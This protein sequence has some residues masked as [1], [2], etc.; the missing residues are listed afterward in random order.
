MLDS[1][2]LGDLRA[3]LDYEKLIERASPALRLYIATLEQENARLRQELMELRESTGRR[4]RSAEARAGRAEAAVARIETV[5]RPND[6]M[7]ITI[8][9][10]GLA[11]RTAL[12]DYPTQHRGGTGVFDI[13]TSRE[14]L[15][16]HLLVARAGAS[17]VLFTTRGRVFRL[18]VDT[19]PLTEV[20]SRGVSL[21]ER[22]MFTPDEA[23]GAAVAL[24]EEDKGTIVLVA[25]ANGW[26][27]SWHRNYLGPRLQAGTL[28]YD[29]P[30]G[31]GPP[32]A[33]VLSDGEGDV[34]IALR[35]GLAYRFA[36]SL[37]RR[38]GVRG[39]Q[40]HPE[41]RVAGLASVHEGSH[42]LLVTANGQGARR[43]VDTFAANKSPGGQ[44]KIIIK[45]DALVAVRAVAEDD[46]ALCISGFAKI[47]RFPVAEVPVKAGSVQGV[48][49][50]DCRGDE[51]AAMAIAPALQEAS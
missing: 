17:L 9:R 47:I 8:T 14:D 7:V 18:A 43:A 3:D 21:P 31:G 22:L 12:N 28:L 5:Q 23:V 49:I 32:V 15:V 42:V 25:T 51:L 39:I 36:E 26:V 46:D 30:R 2:M 48:N 29:P 10:Q 16:A 11:K 19:L 45:S 35:S 1:D 33:A 50:L 34:L 4:Q 44:G 37:V 6:V 38:E 13:N 41:D 24:G 27:R 40:V 20:R